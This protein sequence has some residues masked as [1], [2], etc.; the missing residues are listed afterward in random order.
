MDG[1]CKTDFLGEVIG[2]VCCIPSAKVGL[3]LDK[4]FF[5]FSQSFKNAIKF[6][7]RYWPPDAS[8]GQGESES[9]KT[10]GP[11]LLLK[12]PFTRIT[13]DSRIYFYDPVSLLICIILIS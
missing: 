2:E 13:Y 7:L 11:P 3:N 10:R 9:L 6:E 12:V 8:H 1:S 4:S 5:A